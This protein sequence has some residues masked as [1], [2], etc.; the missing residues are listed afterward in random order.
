MKIA[1]VNYRYFVDGG[2]GRYMFN[3]KEI[4]ER[5]GHEVVTFSIKHPKNQPSEQEDYFLESVGD[6]EY[7]ANT[8]K[9]PGNVVKS[10]SRMFFS[11]E[12]KRKFKKL[13]ADTKPDLVYILQFHNKISPSVLY[14][15]REAGI[16]VVHRISDFQY[17]CPN[18]LF[19]NDV[20]GLCT[21]CLEG[22]R[23]SCV[24]YKCVLD[25]KV[26]SAIKAAA[27]QFHDWLGITKLVSQY[28]VPSSFTLGKL[29]EYGIGRVKLNHVP[30]FFNFKERE[31]TPSYQPFFLFVGRLVKH[32]GLQTLIDA[33]AG[34]DYKLKIIGFAADDYEDELKK[35]LEGKKH[36][37]EFLGRKSF[38][39]IVPYLNT[40]RCTI[41]PAEWYENF[42]N[43]I[44]ESFAFKKAVITTDIGSLVEM[45]EDTQNGML[46]RYRDAADLRRCVE[47]MHDNPNEAERMGQNAYATLREKFNPELHYQRLMEVFQKALDKKTA[48]TL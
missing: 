10:F 32:K 43:A 42:P 40:C 44:L 27:K 1:L 15:A 5:N 38:E 8:K 45:V 13:L 22:K 23:L 19:Y 7:F 28:V 37:I 34:T 24:K 39:E 12:A 3:I 47:Y 11:F 30:T 18:A 21:D 33:F 20:K 31:E 25:S 14:V 41:S 16:P 36:S 35:S 9:T 17:M 46:F 26:Y 29:N 6:E 2:P 4:L 48:A